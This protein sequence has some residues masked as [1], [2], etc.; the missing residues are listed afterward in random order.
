M[1]RRQ[2]RR[3]GQGPVEDQKARKIGGRS[4]RFASSAATK[5]TPPRTPHRS[6]GGVE[7]SKAGRGDQQELERLR[8]A[9]PIV[10]EHEVTEAQN[11]GGMTPSNRSALSSPYAG[12]VIAPATALNSL[13]YRRLEEEDRLPRVSRVQRGGE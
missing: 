11:E 3:A 4:P 12:A 9:H 5:H 8:E 10:A 2:Q 1:R 7:H 13:V 6:S